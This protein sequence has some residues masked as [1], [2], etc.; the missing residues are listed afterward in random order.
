MPGNLH[1]NCVYQLIEM[2]RFY[3]LFFFLSSFSFSFNP[4][5]D[6]YWKSSL[7]EK[8]NRPIDFFTNCYQP[9]VSKQS[10][11]NCSNMCSRVRLESTKNLNEGCS[12]YFFKINSLVSIAIV[13]LEIIH[14]HW[15]LEIKWC[16]FPWSSTQ[17][18]K[19]FTCKFTFWQCNK[20][21][22]VH[23][24]IQSTSM[25]LARLYGRQ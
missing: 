20:I 18:P 21:L 8:I 23:L 6:P 11:S 24:K 5:S 22:L 4:F 7:E 25:Y 17:W 9:W 3:S 1:S 13:Y 10:D 15:Y 14:I 2:I 16:F 12:T 19:I